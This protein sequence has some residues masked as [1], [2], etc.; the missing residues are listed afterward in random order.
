MLEFA[1]AVGGF[2]AGVALLTAPDGASLGWSTASLDGTPFSNYVVPA[3]FLLTLT[4]VFPALVAIATLARRPWSMWGHLVMGGLSVAWIGGQILTIGYISLLQP[5][6]GA[7]AFLI[8][9]LGLMLYAQA[10]DEAIAS[11]GPARSGPI[12]PTGVRG[13]GGPLRQP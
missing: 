2:M 3:L 10:R 11:G 7:I 5:I 12:A 8:T 13:V 9:T 1:L 6:F 4:G